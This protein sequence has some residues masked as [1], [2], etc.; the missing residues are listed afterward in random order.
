MGSMA[1]TAGLDGK[2]HK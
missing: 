1:E 2:S